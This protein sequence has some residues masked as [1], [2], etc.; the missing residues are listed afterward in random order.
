M[1]FFSTF[2]RTVLNLQLTGTEQ[3]TGVATL[4]ACY[5]KQSRDPTQQQIFGWF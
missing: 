2:T 5:M 4:L 3:Q 1:P